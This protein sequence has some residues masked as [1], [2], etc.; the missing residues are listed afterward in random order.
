VAHPLL[1]KIFLATPHALAAI[2]VPVSSGRSVAADAT[3]AAIIAAAVP[4]AVVDA[5]TAVA[6]ARNAVAAAVLDKDLSAVPA[7]PVARVTIADIRVDITPVHR[8]A[9]NLFPRC[10]RP[11]RM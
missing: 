1:A 11:V 5:Q 9:R 10:S 3:V 4:I 2:R 8:A 7:A 6:V